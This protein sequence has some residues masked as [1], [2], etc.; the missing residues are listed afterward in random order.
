[1]MQG[2]WLT[3][4]VRVCAGGRGYP[5]DMSTTTTASPQASGAIPG[6]EDCRGHWHELESGEERAC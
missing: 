2:A 3:P 4:S 5:G 6:F 1:M